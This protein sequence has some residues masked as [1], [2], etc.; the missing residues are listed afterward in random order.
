MEGLIRTIDEAVASNNYSALENLFATGWQAV[1]P[2]EQRSLAA[3]FLVR[4]V[5]TPQF[6]PAAFGSLQPT[7]LVALGHLPSTVE[8]AAD[9]KLRQI[10]FDYLIEQGRYSEGSTIL[11]GTRIHDDGVYCLDAEQ[12][13]NVWIQVAEGYLADDAPEKAEGAV[14]HIVQPP[15]EALLLLRYKSVT[16]RVLDSNRKFLEAARR[17]HELSQSESISLD[18]QTVF[19]ERAVTCA[20][21]APPHAWKDRVLGQLVK[22]ER[23][24][25]LDER[26]HPKLLRQMQRHEIL[27]YPQAFAETLAE[28]QQ[29]VAGNGLTVLQGTLLQHNCLAVARLYESIRL[30]ALAKVLGTTAEQ[31]ESTVA[32]MIRDGSLQASLDQVAGLLQFRSTTVAD[33]KVT[34]FCM[35]MDR[36]S[37]AVVAASTR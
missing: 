30:T 24:S 11:A 23:L 21:L 22:D 32:K 29:A 35:E 26:P 33:D 14:N 27:E 10:L 18:E 6:L 34:E 16:A 9:S 13:A 25:L 19:L 20:V 1:G 37:K 3:H 2:G 31:A 5:G 36:V 15:T 4:A 28:H 7:F 12:R 17:Y 8:G